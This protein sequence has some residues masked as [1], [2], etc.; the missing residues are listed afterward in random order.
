MYSQNEVQE[1]IQS[2]LN[3]INAA[4]YATNPKKHFSKMLRK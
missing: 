4:F 1:D 2:K 3:N